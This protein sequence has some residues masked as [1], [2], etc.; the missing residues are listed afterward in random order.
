[1]FGFL[2]LYWYFKELSKAV[3]NY[4]LRSMAT[5]ILFPDRLKA[6]EIWTPFEEGNVPIP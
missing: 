6:A 4:L 5:K 1:M 2:L 3:S